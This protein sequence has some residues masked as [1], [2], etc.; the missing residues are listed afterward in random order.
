MSLHYIVKLEMLIVVH[1]LPLSFCEK[2][3]HLSG[4]GLQIRQI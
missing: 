3:L 1:V 4:C 2:K